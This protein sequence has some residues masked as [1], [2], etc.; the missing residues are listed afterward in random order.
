MINI[1]GL[2]HVVLR[3]VDMDRMCGFYRDVLGCR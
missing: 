1:R 3:V 2:D